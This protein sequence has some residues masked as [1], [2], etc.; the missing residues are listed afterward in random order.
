MSAAT[1]SMLSGI[2]DQHAGVEH[3]IVSEH[4][5]ED[6]GQRQEGEALVALAEI[7]QPDA[8]GDVGRD[9]P[10]RQHDAL[11]VAG[12]P[13]G[14]DQRGEIIRAGAER[15][16]A[17]SPGARA[18]AA[19]PQASNSPKLSTPG[20]RT[21]ASN[22]TMWRSAGSRVAD[23]ERFLELGGGRHQEHRARRSRAGCTRPDGREAWDRSARRCI[24]RQGR[25]SRRWPTPADSPTGSPPGRRRGGR[26]RSS[27]TLAA[28]TCSASA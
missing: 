15:A 4:P 7:E 11:G 5:L 14:V 10:V 19:R 8:G 25:R 16:G 27:P 12:G 26:A 3:R 28:C 2:V 21:P 17:A 24:A 6:V 13:G 22:A 18:S 1:V 9:V 23:R 20:P